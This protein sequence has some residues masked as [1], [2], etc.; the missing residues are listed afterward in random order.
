MRL[1]EAIIA[2]NHAALEGKR[3]V[4][5]FDCYRECL[6]LAG[7]TCIDV[8]LNQLFPGALGLDEE[9]FIWLRNAGNVVT[10]TTSSTTRSISLAV[11]LKGAREIAV[12]GHTDC[13]MAKLSMNDLLDRLKAAGI[14]RNTLTIPN[15]HEFFGLFGNEQSNVL[16]AVNYLRTSPLIPAKIPVHGLVI[17]TQTGR[18]DWVVNGYEAPGLMQVPQTT[19]RELVAEA[20]P[21]NAPPLVTETLGKIAESIDPL[22]AKEWDAMT[23]KV[24]AKVQ[25]KVDHLPKPPRITAHPTPPPPKLTPRKKDAGPFR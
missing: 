2:A 5:K 1:L 25:E 12:I 22:V 20:I 3:G 18:L 4:A 10:S 7:L 21:I 6:P 24:A 23:A 13:K 17:D 8:R 15:L 19:L 11:M 9:Q 16:R 14:D